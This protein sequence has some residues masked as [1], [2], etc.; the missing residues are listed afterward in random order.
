MAK[1]AARDTF[2]DHF[3]HDRPTKIGNWI[4]KGFSLKLFRY[5]N[6]EP[7]CRVLEIGPGRGVFADLCLKSD[8]EYF[9]V[10]PNRQM[11]AS[12]EERGAEVICAMV[13]PLPRID[14]KFDIVVMVNVMEHMNSM[15]EALQVTQDVREMLRPKGKFVIQSPDYLN[16]RLNFFNGDF[17]HN[18][19][20]T[21]RRLEQL[22]VN[23]GFNNVRSCY[24]SGPLTGFMGFLVS[25]LA[26]RLPFGFL[27]AL[28]PDNKV[29]HKLYKLQTTFLRTV[30]ILGERPD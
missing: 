22:L 7:G 21:R 10:E 1:D 30:L 4:T 12:L 24:F 5:S 3:A 26:S 2:Y 6:V 29:F 16:W 18:Y 17:S 25:V 28:F 9:A 27:N 23:A 13:P 14:K 11:A 20:T 8:V 15:Q 19:V